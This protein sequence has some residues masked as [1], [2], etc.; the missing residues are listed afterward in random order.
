[1][2]KGDVIGNQVATFDQSNAINGYDLLMIGGISKHD[3]LKILGFV[4]R[5]VRTT[6]LGFFR[7]LVPPLL[8]HILKLLLS[9]LSTI[10][11]R[12]F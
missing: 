12:R 1:L 5:K 6:V 3:Q 2:N 9:I 10:R 7:Q 11:S 4:K 8:I